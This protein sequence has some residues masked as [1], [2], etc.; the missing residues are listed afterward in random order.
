MERRAFLR[1]G[2]AAGVAAP[3]LSLPERLLASEPVP[4]VPGLRAPIRLSSNENPLGMP[5][6][7]RKAVIAALVNGNR[8]PM[9]KEELTDAVAKKHGVKPENV[10]LGNGSTE[11]LQMVVQSL[12]GPGTRLVIG[13]PTFEHVEAYA[14]PFHMEVVKVPLRPDHTLD[15]SAMRQAA[16]GARGPALVFVCNPNNPTGTIVPCDDV[17][18]WIRASTER[19]VF[20]VDEAYFDFVEDPGYRTLTPLTSLPNVIVSRTFSKIYGL[21]GLRVGYGIALE[22]TAD[23]LNEFAANTNLNQLGIAAARACI[24]DQAYMKRSLQ[25]NRQSREIAKKTLGE[26][27]IEA[28]PSHTNFFMHRIPGEVGEHIRHMA[29]AGITIGRAFPPMLEW[30]RVSLGTPEEMGVWA[31]AMRDFRRKSWV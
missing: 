28:L 18:S 25:V 22:E 3:F 21:A 4:F 23:R 14:A 24:D 26:L 5:E 17:E 6:S 13:D 10:V 30:S 1:S 7:A 31:E 29:D 27:G 15:L 16:R 19:T 11:I 12:A 2:V 8:Y 9:G 20:L